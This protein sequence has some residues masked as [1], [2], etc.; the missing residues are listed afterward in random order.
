MKSY[1]FTILSFIFFAPAAMADWASGGGGLILD[2]QNPWFLPNTKEATYCIDI[3]Y[4]NFHLDFVKT[5][6]IVVKA[7]DYWKKEGAD[8]EGYAFFDNEKV[9]IATQKFVLK[10]CAEKVDLTFQMGHLNEIQRTYIQ[11]PS[12]FAGAAIRTEYDKVNMR[13][14]GFVYISPESGPQRFKGFEVEKPWQV[15]DGAMLYRVLLH[16]LGHVFGIAHMGQPHDLMSSGYIESLMGLEVRYLDFRMPDFFRFRGDD[17]DRQTGF[18]NIHGINSKILDF[19]GAAPNTIGLSTDAQN[20]TTVNVMASFAG[21]AP[22]ELT[23][24][25]IGTITFKLEKGFPD[26]MG[27]VM[28]Y[29][30]TEQKVYTIPRGFE[31]VRTIYGPQVHHRRREGIYKSLDGKV[32]HQV[33]IELNPSSTSIGVGAVMDG[34]LYANIFNIDWSKK[35]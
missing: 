34:K 16:E 15:A 6:E 19:F 26:I 25:H 13:G 27:G 33:I 35:K 29:L 8:T 17:G 12:D 30:P 5:N 20:T 7:L 23:K 24:E 31:K 22:G 10:D 32:E 28:I 18:M 2:S 11:T 9:K 1:V 14:R 21:S 4:E 3:D